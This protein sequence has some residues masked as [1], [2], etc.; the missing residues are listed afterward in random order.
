MD[1]RNI[2]DLRSANF[3]YLSLHAHLHMWSRR[4]RYESSQN[5]LGEMHIC[6]SFSLPLS[7]PRHLH[8]SPRGF[9][10]SGGAKHSSDVSPGTTSGHFKQ[11]HLDHVLF[12]FL[13][14]VK[15]WGTYS[16]RKCK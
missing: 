5:S 4:L 14:G 13:D 10:I 2:N 8:L 15:H 6:R 11:Y 7:P 12:S 16:Q 9:T 3:F 1:V